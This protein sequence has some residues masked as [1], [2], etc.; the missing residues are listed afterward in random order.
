M[1]K[2]MIPPYKYDKESETVID[3]YI[4]PKCYIV[5][6]E[7]KR[8]VRCAKIK[9]RRSSFIYYSICSKCKKKK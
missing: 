5:I 9:V 4:C 7:V 3:R 1:Q 6:K 2:I 8:D